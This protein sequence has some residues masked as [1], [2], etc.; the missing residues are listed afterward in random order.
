MNTKISQNEDKR[1]CVKCVSLCLYLSLCPLV[2]C[3]SVC[4]SVLCGSQ[5]LEK[6][7]IHWSSFSINFSY[8]P[9]LFEQT[10]SS[11]LAR[12]VWESRK[13]CS[14][15]LTSGLHSLQVFENHNISIIRARH[16]ETHFTHNLFSSFWL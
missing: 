9:T 11:K 10:F 4:F 8:F 1:L 14:K 12:K 13:T 6:Y 2:H 16:R 5:T 3:S 7:T 15:T